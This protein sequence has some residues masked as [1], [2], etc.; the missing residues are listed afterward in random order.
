MGLIS[1]G[2]TLLA[3]I[4]RHLQGHCRISALTS[5]T[6]Q[7][8]IDFLLRQLCSYCHTSFIHMLWDRVQRNHE[9]I[10]ARLTRTPMN[11]KP[12]TSD[13]M[14]MTINWRMHTRGYLPGIQNL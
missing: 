6:C 3:L 8:D 11:H 5:M 4:P 10:R 9:K 7:S 1:E 13:L 14:Q 2:L 12:V